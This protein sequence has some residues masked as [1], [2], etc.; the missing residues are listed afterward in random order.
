M[1]DTDQK[2]IDM[3]TAVISTE[4]AAISALTARISNQFIKA[5]NLLLACKGRVVV[6]G[7]GKS[8]HIGN[9][10]AAT[11]AS[12]GTPAFFIHPAEASHGD[13]G[14]ITKDDV[15]LVLS[16][17]GET[18]EITSIL[19]LIK[20]QNIPIVSVTGNPNASIAMLAD[21]NLDVS[22][23]KEACPLKLAPTASTT[24]TLVM[25][26]ALAITLL[27]AKGFTQDDFAQ[28]HPGGALGKKLLSRVS[29]LMHSGK[30]MPI[31]KSD[32]PFTRAITEITQKCL[33][34]TLVVNEKGVL[35]GIVSDGDIRRAIENNSSLKIE[36]TPTSTF[37]TKNP[38]AITQ[39]MLATEALRL[40]EEVKITG[41]PV[42]NEKQEPIGLLH[43]HDI[44]RAGIL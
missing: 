14:M 40:M 22:I 19:P 44:L 1:K 25:G 9:K 2:I 34:H 12:T 8:G 21:V 32:S 38:R 20:M 28:S 26:D 37:M 5:H 3:A 24:A 7:I 18:I 29:A 39:E 17:S 11:L 36:N 15:L 31:V 10:I 41:L 4:E 30:A 13:L 35:A 6:M 27:S 33:G 16:Y 42:V 23:E 43:L